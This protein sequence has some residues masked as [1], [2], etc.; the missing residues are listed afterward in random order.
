MRVHVVIYVVHLRGKTY[1]RV[2]SAYRTRRRAIVKL[3][4]DEASNHLGA[5]SDRMIVEV[6]LE[7]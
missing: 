4:E 7:E 5:H 6:E 1:P 2:L 3:G